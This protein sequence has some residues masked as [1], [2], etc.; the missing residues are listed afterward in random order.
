M[1]K[2]LALL[3]LAPLTLAAAT[4]NWPGFVRQAPGGAYVMGNPQ[5]KLKVVEYLSF[6]CSHCAHFVE[7]GGK[8]LKANYIAKGQVSLELRNAVR[9]QLDMT[10]ALLSRCGGAAKVFGNSELLFSTQAEW[11]GKVDSFVAAQGEKLKA[12]PMNAQLQAIAKGTGMTAIMARRGFTPAQLNACL[13]SRP[14]QQHIA[15]M[16]KEAWQTRKIR[17]TPS[18]LIN[19]TA[20]SGSH[21]PDLDSALQA[22]LAA[23]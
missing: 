13:I 4:P 8:P 18:F 20:V 9:D 19:G 1:K 16:T 21:W 2:A 15:D 11:G 14:A 5:A 17:G 6:T 7:E 22:A 23:R 3:F 10:A 12:L